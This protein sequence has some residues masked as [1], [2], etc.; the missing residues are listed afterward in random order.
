MPS[1]SLNTLFPRAHHASI[2]LGSG[3][4]FTIDSMRGPSSSPITGQD[5]GRRNLDRHESNMDVFG[6]SNE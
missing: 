3:S 1:V 2:T 5:L 6:I 4:T